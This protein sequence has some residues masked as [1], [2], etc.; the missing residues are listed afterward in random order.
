[1]AVVPLDVPNQV[2]LASQKPTAM[3]QWLL[4]LLI[5]QS[6]KLLK[7]QWFLECLGVSA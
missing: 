2:E 3:V 1:M 6:S 7:A 4:R 5:F